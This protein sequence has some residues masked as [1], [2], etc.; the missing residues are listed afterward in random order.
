MALEPSVLLLD[1]PAASLSQTESAELAAIVRRLASQWGIG[2]LVVEHDMAFV[3]EVCDRIVVMEFG[4][5]IAEGTPAEIRSNPAVIAAY[6][7]HSEDEGAGPAEATVGRA[8]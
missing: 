3:M 6:L 7:G 5:Q 2:I 4:R 1:E 8:S